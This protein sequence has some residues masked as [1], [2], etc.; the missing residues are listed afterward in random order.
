MTHAPSSRAH[1]TH[2]TAATARVDQFRRELRSL[3]PAPVRAADLAAFRGVAR[4]HLPL[5]G[6]LLPR[7]SRA[8]NH[9][10][11]WMVLAMGMA[12]GGGRSRRRAAL[13]GMFALAA[14]SAITNLPVKLLTGRQRPDLG[15]VPE[16]R[17]LARVPT[18]TSFPSGHSASAFAFATGVAMERPRWRL[19]MFTLAGAVAL[20]RVYTGVHYPG[21]VLVGAS[22]GVA[23]A[24]GTRR[25]WPLADDTPALAEPVEDPPPLPAPDGEGL[26]IVANSGAG[27]ALSAGPAGRLRR[28]LPG[29]RIVEA[30]PGE[31]L[32][33]VLERAAS[34]ARVLGVAGGDGSASAAAAVAHR[35]GLPLLVVPAGTLNH[36]AQDL[37][38]EELSDAV[39]AVKDG[40][41]AAVDLGEVDGHPFVNAAAI[42]LYPHL[43]TA[44][45]RLED[46]IGKWPAAAWSLLRVMLTHPPA[47]L[48]VN[49]ERRRLWL[50]FVGNGRYPD[51]GLAPSGRRRL[52]DGLLDVRLVD[53]E[54]PWARLRVLVSLLTG[55]LGTC[56]SYEHWTAETL[57]VRALDGR[58]RIATDGE[59]WYASPSFT[60]RK[61]P[62]GL[63]VLRPGPPPAGP[64]G[65]G[66][67]RHRPR[68]NRT[69]HAC[70]P[71]HA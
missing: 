62:R 63:L 61:R 17:R 41:V 38:A 9:S 68:R 48:E 37:G 20:S 34:D 3:V 1:R 26:V 65:R 31:D 30:G 2:L 13:R 57:S 6:P 52:D 24:R 22:I 7:L 5:I 42:G 15:V 8:A 36:F 4:T 59:S 49:G 44:R 28:R 21:D 67:L 19:P 39:A 25:V 53:A 16:I 40:H 64:P 14:T 51:P 43:V 12:A 58:L 45:E 56:A 71:D 46:R 23:V 50:L 66:P 11:L 32:P 35:H 69:T 60:V 27:N 18:S 47:D 33:T 29:A 10:R 70:P 55:R 54:T